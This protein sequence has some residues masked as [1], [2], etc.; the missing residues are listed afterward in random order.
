MSNDPGPRQLRQSQPEPGSAALAQLIATV[1]LALCTL[2][3]ATTVSIGLARADW[4]A[5]MGIHVVQ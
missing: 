5:P 4:P 3:A 1:T 2:I